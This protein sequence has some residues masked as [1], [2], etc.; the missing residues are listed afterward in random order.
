[1]F[2]FLKKK[3]SEVVD[4]ISGK[5]KIKSE[6]RPAPIEQKPAETRNGTLSENQVKPEVESAATDI[7]KVE[8][9]V[10]QNQTL[11][12]QIKESAATNIGKVE[13]EPATDLSEKVETTV[14]IHEE[15]GKEG[16]EIIETGLREEIESEKTREFEENAPTRPGLEEKKETLPEFGDAKTV[17]TTTGLREED[18]TP[19]P[20]KEE[21]EIA[22]DGKKSFF[23]RLTE[24]VVKTVTEKRLSREDVLPMLEN[25]ESGLVEADVAIEVAEKVGNDLIE[26]LTSSD[27]KRG[28]ER[29]VIISAFRKSLLE[30]L[31]VPKI[32]FDTLAKEKKP[33]LMVFWGFNGAGKTTSLAKTAGWLKEKGYT[34]CFAAADTFRAG[35]EEQLEAHAKKLGIKLIKHKYGSDPAAV[36]FDAVEHARSKGIDFVLADTAGRAHTNMNLMEQMKKIV[37]VNRPDVKVLVIDSLTGNDALEQA[38]SYGEVGVDTVIFT[39]VDVNEKGGAVLSVTYELKKPILFLGIGQEYKDF[40]EFDA[41][42]FVDAILNPE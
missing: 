10:Q 33:V 20:K 8:I 16:M 4:S 37:R 40:Q 13:I 35:A 1:M 27:I 11:E 18:Q 36:I 28:R 9:A 26:T 42:K 3:L 6:E 2:G 31:N 12:G 14:D 7:G 29:E 25:I 24:K 17:D 32:D 15:S 38:R 39:K 23:K 30:I 22:K 34:C 21:V 41:E 5:V 19:L